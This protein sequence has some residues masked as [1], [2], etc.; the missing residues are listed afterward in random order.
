MQVDARGGLLVAANFASDAVQ[1]H[2]ALVGIGTVSVDPAD[3]VGAGFFNTDITITGVAVGDL[4]L[5]QPPQTLEDAL[6]LVGAGV[7]S[8]NT[9]R[10]KMEATGA[11]NG[12]ARE[13][14]YLHFA[15]VEP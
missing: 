13:W 12:A 9:V 1:K 15:K 2:A 6:R 8:A 11:V 7:Q 14:A 5:I 10:I 3:Q 4:V